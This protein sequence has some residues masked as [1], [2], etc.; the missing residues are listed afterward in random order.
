VLVATTNDHKYLSNQT[1]NRRIWP[2]KTGKKIRVD[3][4]E[5]DREQ[6][7]AEAVW[8]YESGFRWHL[9]EDAEADARE[10]QESR[11]EIHAWEEPISN[12][13]AQNEDMILRAGYITVAQVLKKAL[14]ISAG[15]WKK[16]DEMKVAEILTSAFGWR[17]GGERPEEPLR[18][19]VP[20]VGR[21]YPYYPPDDA[22]A[23]AAS[24]DAIDE[25]RLDPCPSQ[26]F[27]RLAQFWPEDGQEIRRRSGDV[28]SCPIC[29][30][31]LPTERERVAGV[32]P[33]GPAVTVWPYGYRSPGGQQC[34]PVPP[35]GCS[36][37]IRDGTGH[38]SESCDRDE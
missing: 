9:D 38:P 7:I 36:R 32:V 4:I 37:A 1:G 21:I 8:L 31:L 25:A 6:L 13:I 35:V 14:K 11:R 29:P 23:E 30:I 18:R 33:D 10:E 22:E 24:S 5:R 34:P 19:R 12:W 2:V 27:E 16:N 28:Q 3:D 15:Q 20:G 26:P 17:P